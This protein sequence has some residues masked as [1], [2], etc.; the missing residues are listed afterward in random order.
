MPPVPTVRSSQSLHPSLLSSV[1]PSP[2]LV[3]L[4][5]TSLSA[6]LYCPASHVVHDPGLDPL[7]PFKYFPGPQ[8]VEHCVHFPLRR[9]SLVWHDV[10]ADW[11]AFG[12]PLAQSWQ[13]ETSCFPMSL[14]TFPVGQSKQSVLSPFSYLPLGQSSQEESCV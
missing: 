5:T 7:H 2:Q 1:L 6:L 10:Q 4:V 3:Q 11:S 8:L 9:Y 13:S 12:S 14:F